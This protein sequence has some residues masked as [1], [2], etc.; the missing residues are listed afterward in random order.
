[1]LIMA[2]LESEGVNICFMNPKD[3]FII[4]LT[5]VCPNIYIWQRREKINNTKWYV[6][7]DMTNQFFNEYVEICMLLASRFTRNILYRIVHFKFIFK[8][9]TG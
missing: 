5:L 8:H 3:F 4:V 7:A 2:P 1:M 9:L 6:H